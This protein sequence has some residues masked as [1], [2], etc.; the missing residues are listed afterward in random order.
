MPALLPLWSFLTLKKCSH[1][2]FT[3]LFT[4]CDKGTA[5]ALCTCKRG[6][7]SEGA[8]GQKSSDY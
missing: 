4:V 6:V 8:V 7:I 5:M 1:W 3:E 2:K